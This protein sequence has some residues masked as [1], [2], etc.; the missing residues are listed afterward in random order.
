MGILSKLFGNKKTYEVDEQHKEQGKRKFSPVLPT[1]MHD[2]PASLAKYVDKKMPVLVIGGKYHQTQVVLTSNPNEKKFT[3]S[4]GK[5]YP[6]VTIGMVMGTEGVKE[7][8]K[9][10]FVL[11]FPKNIKH[12]TLG[13]RYDEYCASLPP[14][15][16]YEG[17]NEDKIPADADMEIS[18]YLNRLADTLAYCRDVEKKQ[19][20]VV[21]E[22]YY[23]FL[24]GHH[25]WE[26]DAYDDLLELY[27]N[28]GKN[29]AFEALRL[30]SIDHFSKR[31]ERME[32]QLTA[33]AE[34]QGV[35]EMATEAIRKG[36]KVSYFRGLF[37]LYDPFPCIEH[38]KRLIP[39]FSGPE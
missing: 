8:Q 14:F 3:A 2:E 30:Y 29:D 34:Q 23:L 16:F 24:I 20:F 26:P 35:K 39:I 4:N 31:R 15:D 25:P 27:R 28:N 9:K 33:L 12:P 32:R 1:L 11:T 37:T 6:G 13:E 36:E 7:Q 17:D 18:D 10:N 38:W 21:A 5:A 19:G 22:Q